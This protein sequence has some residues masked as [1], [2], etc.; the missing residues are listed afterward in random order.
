MLNDL[1]YRVRT[2]RKAPL[3]TLAIETTTALGIG[4]VAIGRASD[5]PASPEGA[6]AVSSVLRLTKSSPNAV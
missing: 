6:R 2:L 3:F 1:R 4:V 5:Q